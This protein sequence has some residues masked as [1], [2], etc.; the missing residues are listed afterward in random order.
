MLKQT[1]LIASL[2]AFTGTTFAGE[3]KQP[4]TK[5][6]QKFEGK[7]PAPPSKEEMEKRRADFDARL[8][9][10]DEQKAQAKVIREKGQKE[11]KPVMEKKKATFEKIKAIKADT[12]LSDEQKAAKIKPLKEELKKLKQEARTLR[13]KNQQEFEAILTDSQKKEL[14]KMKAEG[15][16]NFEGQRKKQ[17]KKPQRRK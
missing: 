9:L 10:T 11:M 12:K 4:P 7:R 13:E 15:K 3:F 1:L 17:G 8:Q 14:A 16:K 2:L 6:P 5:A